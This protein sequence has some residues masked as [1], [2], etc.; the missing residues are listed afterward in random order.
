MMK[1]WN[2]FC[3]RNAQTDWKRT[4]ERIEILQKSLKSWLAL[5]KQ[6]FGICLEQNHKVLRETSWWGPWS[7][8]SHI[9]RWQT[10]GHF[11][12]LG[13]SNGNWTKLPEEPMAVIKHIHPFWVSKIL[14]LQTTGGKIFIKYNDTHFSLWVLATGS[15][16]VEIQITPCSDQQDH[17][18]TRFLKMWACE[19]RTERTWYIR[20]Q[21]KPPKWIL[22]SW[23]GEMA[24]L[25]NH[26]RLFGHPVQKRLIRNENGKIGP[27]FP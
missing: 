8:S 26:Q 18:D 11:R 13:S 25:K 3:R 24:S 10:H 2:I 17:A 15:D 6:S 23:L 7:G 22:A 9:D 19:K 5:K 27:I 21:D 20:V 14:I 1:V 12:T 4:I 16:K